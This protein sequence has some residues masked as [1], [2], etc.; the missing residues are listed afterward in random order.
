MSYGIMPYMVNLQNVESC[1]AI[2]DEKKKSEVM[3]GAK[4]FIDDM[5]MQF[6]VPVD[7]I[8]QAFLDGSIINKSSPFIHWYFIESL[9]QKYGNMLENEYWYPA[10][11]DILYQFKSLKLYD[12][13]IEGLEAADDLP[14]VFVCRNKDLGALLSDTLYYF[15]DKE[16]KGEFIFWILLC[17][18]YDKDLV[19]Y[20]Y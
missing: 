1:F 15:V 5:M 19:L 14:T 18:K 7:G 20:Y 16:M 4:E 12:I 13:N 10:N 9:I 3:Q 2:E 6:G 17:N 8:V 11:I